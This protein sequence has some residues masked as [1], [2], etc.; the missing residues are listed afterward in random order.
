MLLLLPLLLSPVASQG[1][2]LASQL[3]ANP[4]EPPESWAWGDHPNGVGYKAKGGLSLDQCIKNPHQ[5]NTLLCSE[6]VKQISYWQCFKNPQVQK[7]KLC[8]RPG[9]F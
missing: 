5:A 9:W 6:A 8:M 1:V 4:I 7:T 2:Q 3:P